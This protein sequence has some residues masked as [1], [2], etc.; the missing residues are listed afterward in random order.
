M[1]GK[2]VTGRIVRDKTMI[3]EKKYEDKS[4]WLALGLI[5]IFS[6]IVIIIS[7]EDGTIPVGAFVSP[8]SSASEGQQNVQTITGSSEI[9]VSEAEGPGSTGGFIDRE[10]IAR[11]RAANGT[12]TKDK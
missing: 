12:N 11:E 1:A 7:A 2:T 3:G 8:A 5:A 9:E 10:R 6:T 4:F